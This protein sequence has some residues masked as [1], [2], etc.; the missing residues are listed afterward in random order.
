MVSGWAFGAEKVE[1]NRDK[2]DAEAIYRLLEEKI[3]PLYY[4]SRNHEISHGW[5]A[6]MKEAIKTCGSQF[7]ARRMVL[8][9]LN[10]F[11][12]KALQNRVPD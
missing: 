10:K 1:G 7:S 3:I 9:Y 5:V 11:Y 2:A 4:R 8:E 12:E 6:V